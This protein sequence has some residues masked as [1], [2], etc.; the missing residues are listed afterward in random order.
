VVKE[1]GGI[2]IVQDPLDALSIHAFKPISSVVTDHILHL[3]EISAKPIELAGDNWPVE[4]AEVS[5]IQMSAVKVG[6]VPVHYD[7]AC[8]DMTQMKEVEARLADALERWSALVRNAVDPIL[9]VND[10]GD[11]LFA[12][13]PVP[14][15]KGSV[16][17]ATGTEL[18]TGLEKRG[19]IFD[20]V[21]GDD[22]RKV[23]Q[24]LRQVFKAGVTARC[25]VANAQRQR[26][27]SLDFGPMR[28]TRADCAP[29]VTTLVVRDITETKLAEDRLRI[30]ADRCG[31]CRCTGNARARKNGRG[32]PGRYTTSSGRPSQC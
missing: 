12:S 1:Q 21:A 9:I 6:R 17:D 11:V 8:I 19:S 2:V 25:V 20:F 26:W 27:F 5:L 23:R 28:P 10:T 32:S 22:Q 18:I 29:P 30:L 24:T 31:N 16:L 14:G 4:Q 7:I 3:R 15:G 13:K